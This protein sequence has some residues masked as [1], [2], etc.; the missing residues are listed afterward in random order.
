[1]KGK[2]YT[3]QMDGPDDEYHLSIVHYTEDAPLGI[4]IHLAK[5]T[6]REFNSLI[7]TLSSKGAD[8]PEWVF[9]KLINPLSEKLP[10]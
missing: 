9:D 10:F 2:I 4:P 1:M 7:A 5:L 8:S 6:P 3:C